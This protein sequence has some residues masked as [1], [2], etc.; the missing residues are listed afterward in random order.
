[1]RSLR[2]GMAQINPTVGDLDGN[3]ERIAAACG[4]AR[5]LDVDLLV[6][7]EMALPGY[8]PEDLLL[9]PAFIA[10]VLERT[11]DLLPHTAGLTAVVGTLERDVDL[12]NAAGKAQVRVGAKLPHLDAWNARRRAIAECYDELLTNTDV[13]TPYVPS[14]VT[15]IYH[16]YCIRA[17][18]RRDALRDHLKTRGIETGIHYPIPLHLQQSLRLHSAREEFVPHLSPTG[19]R[20]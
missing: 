2:I 6:F 1:M 14:Y 17:P 13:V 19:V 15:P 7:P 12:Y 8:P 4:Q 3:F 16:I 5:A 9:K 11:R 10:R 18:G 20:E